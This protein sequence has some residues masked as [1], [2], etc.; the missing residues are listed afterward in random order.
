[1]AYINPETNEIYENLKAAPICY[2]KCD[3]CP[4]IKVAY[5]HGVSVFTD[6]GMRCQDLC[7]T[8]P[9]EVARAFGYRIFD[10]SEMMRTSDLMYMALSNIIN[11]FWQ[12]E[13]IMNGLSQ[14]I[15]LKTL[16]IISCHS[17]MSVLSIPNWKQF[18]LPMQS[19]WKV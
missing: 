19:L 6:R 15:H 3:D 12:A 11:I 10:T 2:Q 5:D 4:M 1:M 13:S 16:G 14:I 7:E 18:G 8:Y 17:I 9:D